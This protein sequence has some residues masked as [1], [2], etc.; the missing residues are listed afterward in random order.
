MSR[1]APASKYDVV[2][3]GAGPGGLTAAAILARAGL[4]VCVL[5]M[6]ARPG[7][8]LAGFRRKDF[9]FDSA[10]HWL[11]QCGPKGSVTR[12]FDLIGR[13]HPQARPQT[14]IR[15]HKSDVIDR[16]LTSDP[17]RLKAEL[18]ADFPHERKGIERFFKDAWYLGRSFD[19]SSSLLRARETMGPLERALFTMRRLRFALPFIKHLG[20]QG[21]KGIPRGLSRY[22]KDPGLHQLFASEQELLACLVPIGWAYF[23]D[24]QSPPEG[25]SQVF[26]EWLV[27]VITSLNG[28]VH[29]RCKVT[30]IRLEHGRCTGV[31]VDRKGESFEIRADQVIAA[32]DVETLYE[33]MLPPDAVPER[34]KQDLQDAVLYSSSVTVSLG[35]DVPAEELG[36]NE[37][38]IFLHRHD[39]GRDEH[40]GEDPHKSGISILAPSL[41]DKSLAPPGMGTLTLYIPAEMRHH[42]R[43]RTDEAWARGEAYEALKKEVA[44]ILIDRV[45][46]ALAPGLREH[47]VICDIATPITHWRYTGN[48]GG[49]MMGAKPGKDNFKAGIAHYRTPVPG[50][51]LG[52]HWAELGG[53]V[54]IAVKAGSNAALI[55]LHDRKHPAFSTWRSYLDRSLPVEQVFDGPGL[56]PYA[57]DWVRQPTPSEKRQ[58][59]AAMDGRHSGPVSEQ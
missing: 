17:D 11:N 20:Y 33:R 23:G 19:R 34:L 14:R 25:G 29:Y 46:R 51:L 4:Q 39:V 56:V 12:V 10:I 9:R 6:D 32:C 47:I 37:E 21:E 35:L 31:V 8:Y 5:E 27:H 43:W 7:G 38:M 54:P 58:Q 42:E 28:E 26:P 36:F 18:I 52:G 57:E 44:D 59:R 13:D 53:G 40:G 16:L 50:L 2:V 3:I 22:F 55:I 41:R 15:R 1:S 48:R 45:E 24:Y 49:S 30:R